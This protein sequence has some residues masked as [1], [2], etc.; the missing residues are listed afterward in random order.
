MVVAWHCRFMPA[1][2]A[3]IFCDPSCNNDAAGPVWEAVRHWRV[4]HSW[5][6]T[7]VAIKEIVRRPWL[8]PA[9]ASP[10]LHKIAKTPATDFSR[11]CE[12]PLL[13]VA[14]CLRR[15]LCRAC[16]NWPPKVRSCRSLALATKQNL[17][18]LPPEVRE[19]RV[20]SAFAVAIGGNADMPFSTAYV[21]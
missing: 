17:G 20:M 11:Y 10:T 15:S 12:W 8:F 3:A 14:R 18:N 9:V 2:G 6:Q 13:V 21:R 5:S 16:L 19:L 4:L 1:F 7:G